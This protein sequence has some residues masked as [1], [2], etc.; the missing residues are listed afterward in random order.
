MLVEGLRC[1]REMGFQ[2]TLLIHEAISSKK[3]TF[4]EACHS[5][6]AVLPGFALTESR[7]WYSAPTRFLRRVR[8]LHKMMKALAPDLIVANGPSEA[9]FLWV[10]SL[11]GRLP[12]APIVTFLHGSPFQFADDQTK[13]ALA[14]RRHFSL[15]RA[16]DPVYR[17]VIPIKCPEMKL[18]ERIKSEI[19]CFVVRA[20][21]RMSRLVFVL[22][23]KNRMEMELLYGIRNVQ[24]VCPGGFGREDLLQQDRP[25]QPL[26]AEL[27]GPVFLSVCRLIKKK[28]V[29][30]L[31][32]AFRGFIDRERQCKATFVIGGMGP[33]ETSLRELAATLGVADRIRFAGFIPDADLLNWYRNCDLFLSADNADYDLT[34]MMALLAAR[35]IVVSTQYEAPPGLP[36]LRRFFFVASPNPAAYAEAID[37]ALA[38][39][40]APLDDADRSEL[41]SMTWESYFRTLLDRSQSLASPVR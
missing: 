4:L 9:R 22:S 5:D 17:E 26:S 13:Y 31:L 19:E 34:V 35:K 15:I 20:G 8:S 24:V 37:L 14:F 32:R 39:S 27:S 18:N 30:L 6:I 38:T 29:D 23:H 28:R 25:Y 10:Y 16:A 12:L 21:V 2:V 1:F 11:A 7:A 40:V 36:A 3:G 33:E 41:D